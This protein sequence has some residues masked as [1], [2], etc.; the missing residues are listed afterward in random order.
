[1]LAFTPMYKNKY[2]KRKD[3]LSLEEL[4]PL[5]RNILEAI[6]RREAIIINVKEMSHVG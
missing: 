2:R 6:I 1:M 3:L 4:V 5:L